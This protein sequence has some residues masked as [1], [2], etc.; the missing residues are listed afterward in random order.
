[1]ADEKQGLVFISCG[2]YHPEEKKLGQDLAAAVSELTPFEGYF[3]ENQNSLEGLSRNIFGAL[4]RCC[5]S[6][7]SCTIGEN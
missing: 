3:A 5:D 6:S 2:Q 7:V 1:M 4:N